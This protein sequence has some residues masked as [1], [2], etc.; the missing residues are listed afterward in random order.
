[1][2]SKFRLNALA[3]TDIGQRSDHN[4]DSVFCEVG[5]HGTTAL[6][7][8]ADGMGGHVA[9]EQA[10]QMALEIV[11]KTM[12][13]WLAKEN[14][15]P[16]EQLTAE[17]D[18]ALSKAVQKANQVV[19]DY[20]QE[21]LAYGSHMGSTIV[22]ALIHQSNVYIANVGDSRAYLYRQG[23]LHRLTEDHSLVE[24][25]VQEGII[26]EQERYD[27]PSANIVTRAIGPKPNVGVDLYGFALE[28]GD[29][30]LL[31]SDGLWE[32][33]RGNEAITRHLQSKHNLTKISQNLISAANE[34][35]GKDNISVVLAECRLA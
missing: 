3:Q 32:M 17:I 29:Y 34:A 9:G 23:H 24:R 33:L 13:P 27:H 15:P 25:F 31:C 11:V 21:N 26:T 18:E 1:M 5:E 10:S 16:S 19:Y 2:K 22:C 12:R 28:D 8:V 30:L 20:A 4:E 35:G 6:L 7:I 14:I